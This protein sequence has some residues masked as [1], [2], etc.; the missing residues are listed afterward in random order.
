M[1]RDTL[2]PSQGSEVTHRLRRLRAQLLEDDPFFGILLLRLKLVEDPSCRTMWTDGVHL[3]FKPAW[4][5]KLRDAP[6]KG[7]M[8]H[9]CLHVIAG[10]PWRRYG[11]DPSDWNDACDHAVN[12]LVRAEGYM[13]PE[14]GLEDPRFEGLWA[15]VIFNMLAQEPQAEPPPSPSQQDGPS[16]NDAAAE[17]PPAGGEDQADE[18]ASDEQPSHG[19]PGSGDAGDEADER[20]EEASPAAD[21]SGKPGQRGKPGRPGRD[22]GAGE[23]RDAPSGHASEED[24]SPEGWAA[25]I[26]AASYGIG[27][28][29][30]GLKRFVAEALA[31]RCDPREVLADFLLRTTQAADFSWARPARRYY[32]TGLYLPSCESVTTGPLVIGVDT[33]GSV[34]D[35]D[36]AQA[37]AII[38]ATLESCNPEYVAVVYCDAAVTH[39]QRF[40]PGDDI[41]LEP[42]GGAGTDFN[43]VFDWV[44]KNEP[45]A[46]AVVYI[47]D[48]QGE[49]PSKETVPTIWLASSAAPRSARAPIGQTV[50]LQS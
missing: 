8:V 36:L 35:S 39:V 27:H 50:W 21:L 43:P 20:S 17:A 37:Q 1:R 18:H 42:R 48:L 47:T 29:S 46:A 7:V 26:L 41:V 24:L 49:F 3:G 2:P 40:E 45:D 9:E 25:A 30:A 13:L 10:H 32:A 38:T 28:R 31:P 44:A 4:C 14:N 5:A 34:P 11:R 15:E 6:L 23:V 16:Q 12:P 33:S 22:P 19:T